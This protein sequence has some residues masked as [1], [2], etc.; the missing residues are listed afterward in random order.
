M[1]TLYI[2]VSFLANEELSLYIV[3]VF[4]SN[5]YYALYFKFGTSK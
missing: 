3:T 5:L 2:F 4:P 1:D